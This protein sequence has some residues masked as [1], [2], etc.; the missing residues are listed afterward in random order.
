MLA[1]LLGHDCILRRQEVVICL[2]EEEEVYPVMGRA[3]K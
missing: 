2:E 1:H 3:F